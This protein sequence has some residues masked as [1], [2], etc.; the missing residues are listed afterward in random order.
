MVV[1]RRVEIRDCPLLLGLELA[2]D[3]LVLA[4]EARASAQ[5]VDRAMLRGCHEPGAGVIRHAR[6]GPLLEG[7]DE[8]VLREILGEPDIAH[9]PCQAGDEPGG[10][11]SPDRVDRSVYIGSRHGYQSDHLPP[12]VQGWRGIAYAIKRLERR[13]PRPACES[14]TLQSSRL[15]RSEFPRRS[16]SP[17][18][19]H[20]LRSDKSR[21]P[22]PSTRRKGRR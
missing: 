17:P 2:S 16:A 14:A 9:D 21:P 18:L 11:D 12:P 20:G 4:I 5:V 13:R 6:L 3:L 7:R 8:C 1:E 10:F 22:A 19:C 15:T